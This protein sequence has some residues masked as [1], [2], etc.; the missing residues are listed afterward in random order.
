VSNGEVFLSSVDLVDL[1]VL[2]GEEVHSKVEL[3]L[4]SV[5]DSIYRHM[6]DEVL[7]ELKFLLGDHVVSEDFKNVLHI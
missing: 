5:R 1:G 7:L 6:F 4:S 2:L 3:F